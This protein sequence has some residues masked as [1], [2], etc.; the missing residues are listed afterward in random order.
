MSEENG[1]VYSG[2]ASA[3]RTTYFVDV[4]QAVNFRFYISI[5]ESRRVSDTGFDQNR[6]FI[7]EENLEDVRDVLSAAFSALQEAQ[8]ERGPLPEGPSSGKYERSG[9]AWTE[10]EEDILRREFDK[11]TDR[12][13][14]AEKLKRSSYAVTLR[15]EKLGLVEK[16]AEKPASA[17]TA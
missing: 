6:I 11:N 7:F 17:G 9:K 1:M 16:P 3:G 2:R 13:R 8:D 15:L 12:D 10:E 5:T 14:I 4:R